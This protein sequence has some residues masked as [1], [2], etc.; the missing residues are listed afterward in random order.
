MP[1]AWAVF[2]AFHHDQFTSTRAASVVNPYS[3]H[4]I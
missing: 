4:T 2:V 3:A 1:I